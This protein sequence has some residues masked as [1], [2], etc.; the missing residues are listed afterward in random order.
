METIQNR[1]NKA[2][3][4]AILEVLWN[5]RG[6][7]PALD[8]HLTGCDINIIVMMTC[9][10]WNLILSKPM[11]NTRNCIRYSFLKAFGRTEF[12]PWHGSGKKL[13]GLLQNLPI[14]YSVRQRQNTFHGNHGQRRR[15]A[16]NERRELFA[17]R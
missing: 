17:Y 14:I 2:L 15:V 11:K 7:R 8:S 4:Y 13:P 5:V 12:Y 6:G 3:P 1:L 10:A 9:D 16:R